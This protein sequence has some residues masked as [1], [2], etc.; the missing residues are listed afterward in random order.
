MNRE[1]IRRRKMTQ[2]KKNVKGED[3]G[4]RMGSRQIRDKSEE[5]EK[6]K[7]GRKTCG[8]ERGG[9]GGEGVVTGGEQ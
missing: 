7:E 5:K 6:C 2:E 3:L 9:G 8:Q 1:G 4:E